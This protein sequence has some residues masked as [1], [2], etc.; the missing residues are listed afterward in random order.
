MRLNRNP[1]NI[2]M[3]CIKCV[4]VLISSVDVSFKEPVM[5][6]FWQFTA[7]L[8]AERSRIVQD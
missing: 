6:T 3:D 7:H 8:D 5:Q 1:V 4:N 2:F